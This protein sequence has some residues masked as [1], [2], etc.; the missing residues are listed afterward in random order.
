M[1]VSIAGLR[2]IGSVG[3]GKAGTLAPG[4][5]GRFSPALRARLPARSLRRQGLDGGAVKEETA[6]A[7]LELGIFG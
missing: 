3:G 4:I 1:T 6:G 7:L 5:S 2:W